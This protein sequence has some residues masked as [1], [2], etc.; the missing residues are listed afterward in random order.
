LRA[1]GLVEIERIAE[2]SSRL[3][4]NRPAM[5]TRPREIGAWIERFSA[6]VRLCPRDGAARPASPRSTG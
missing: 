6:A 4:V 3:I 2:V 5:K 1:N